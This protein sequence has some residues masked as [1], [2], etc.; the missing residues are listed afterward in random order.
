MIDDKN[1]VIFALLVIALCMC[2]LEVPQGNINLINNIVAG[3]LGLAIGRHSNVEKN[4]VTLPKK[5]AD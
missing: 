5:Q 4:K 3:L 1:F 2:G